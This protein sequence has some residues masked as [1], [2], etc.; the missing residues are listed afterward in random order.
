M[1]AIRYPF[2]EIR[3]EVPQFFKRTEF[4]IRPRPAVAGLRRGSHEMMR[5]M[6]ATNSDDA[7]F[8]TL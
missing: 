4:L 3:D 7:R 5:R 1:S 2:P 6:F 8:A